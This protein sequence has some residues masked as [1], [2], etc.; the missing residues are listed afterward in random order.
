MRR[1]LDEPLEDSERM[2]QTAVSRIWQIGP[3]ATLQECRGLAEL[4]KA[5]LSDSAAL[6]FG[7]PLDAEELHSLLERAG[8]VLKNCE[9][10][11]HREEPLPIMPISGRVEHFWKTECEALQRHVPATHA[12][13]PR[14][15][16]PGFLPSFWP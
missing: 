16:H 12:T 14:P 6:Q 1:T 13:R 11:E 5:E 3:V 2:T 7:D 15:L 9:T 10:S 4:I 8:A